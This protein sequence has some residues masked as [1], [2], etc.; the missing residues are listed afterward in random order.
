MNT[1]APIVLLLVFA[2]LCWGAVRQS[3]RVAE[4]EREGE[5]G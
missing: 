2:L 1:I 5:G 4:R 3:K